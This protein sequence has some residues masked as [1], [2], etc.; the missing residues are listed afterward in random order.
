[1]ALED[2]HEVV[3]VS[4]GDSGLQALGAGH[5][6][7]VLL[8]V[9]MP[10]R[11]G[12]EVLQEIRDREIDTTIIM[13]T[14]HREIEKVVE[15]MRAGASDYV[16]KPFKVTE[17]RH[18]IERNLRIVD[19]ERRAQSLEARLM[20]SE[21]DRSHRI[22]FQSE[23]MR[24]ALESLEKAAPTDASVLIQGESGTGKELAA[25]FVHRASARSDGPLVVV[26]C[27]AIPDN[28][29]ES[30]LFGHEKGAFSGATERKIGRLELAHEG[31]AFLDEIGTLP[32]DLQAKL[33]RTLESRVIERIGSTNQIKLDVRWI[34]A[35]NR[36]LAGLV[37]EGLFREDLF[38]R[39]NVIAV[40]L[41]P[42]RGRPEDVPQLCL[43]FLDELAR[44]LKRKPLCLGNEVFEVFQVYEWPG[45]VRELRNIIE[46]LSVLEAGPS[47][48]IAHLPA[49][50]LKA[51]RRSTG[52]DITGSSG[53]RY[54]EAIEGFRRSYIVRSLR[55]AGGNQAEAARQLGLHRNTLIHHI[56]SMSIRPEEYGYIDTS[57]ENS[58]S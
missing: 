19:L 46:R 32:V 35:T 8:D 40:T 29:L 26:N 11:S 36:D 51:Y 6:E 57:P 7:L 41:P 33:L 9:N 1:M 18:A 5:F 12:F 53:S 10:G 24:T 14:V 17:L 21:I 45:N 49:E 22:I 56:R 42:L 55:A 13:V 25:Q 44:D 52:V 15:A 20:A 31:T 37:E 38:Y 16:T 43:H 28:L 4:D 30:E 3:T 2:L 54:K 48:E 47:I 50:M 58:P 27:A 34:A 23:S 39:L